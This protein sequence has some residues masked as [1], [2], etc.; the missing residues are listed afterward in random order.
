[1]EICDPGAVR[2]VLDDPAFV[3]PPLPRVDSPVAIAWLR[4]HVGRFSSGAEHGRR[5]A[6]AVAE[7]ER[8]EPEELRLDARE[9]AAA[10]LRAGG[11]LHVVPVD[12]LAA[13][14][15]CRP[16]STRTSPTPRAPTSRTSRPMSPPQIARSPASSRPA[17]ES[18]TS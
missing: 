9:R 12:T 6:L 5:R 3:V 18:Q 17:E 10:T 8:L 13:A 1:V 2:A 16:T 7:I 4:S 11:S 14:L 15:G